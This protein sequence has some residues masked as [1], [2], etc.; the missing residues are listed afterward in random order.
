MLKSAIAGGDAPAVKVSAHSLKGSSRMVGAARLASVCVRIEQHLARQ[1]LE[2]LERELTALDEE[3]VRLPGAFEA[4]ISP[5][6]D[7]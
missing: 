7:R 4:E 5:K 3:L 2:G 6:T 1:G